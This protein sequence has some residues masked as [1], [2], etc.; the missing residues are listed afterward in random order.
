VEEG[1]DVEF[2]GPTV[3]AIFAGKGR[4]GTPG[5]DNDRLA[6]WRRTAPQID[7]V[8]SVPHVETAHDNIAVVVG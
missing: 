5:V 2:I 7:V 6:L 3:L 8:R 1:I 4:L